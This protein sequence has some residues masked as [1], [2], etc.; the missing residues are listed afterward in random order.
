MYSG[1]KW[2]NPSDLPCWDTCLS[3]F[4]CENKGQYAQCNRCS[5]RHDPEGHR[6]P[7]HIDDRCRCRE[8]ILQYRLKNGHMIQRKFYSDPF[9]GKVVTD[10]ESQDEQEWN[11][12][13]DEQ[14]EKLDDPNFDPIQFDDGSS[15]R[16]F[17]DRA[18][19][20]DNG[21]A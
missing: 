15:T 1:A 2:E 9:A 11:R 17:I 3:C 8:G 10:A 16:D 7:Y 5:G 14:R 18:R 13:V 4:R 21:L 12:F 19:R 6:D 20:G